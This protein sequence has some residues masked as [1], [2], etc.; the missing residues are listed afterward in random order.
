M[1]PGRLGLNELPT[2]SIRPC[3]AEAR[4]G[5]PGAERSTGRGGVDVEDSEDVARRRAGGPGRSHL[6]GLGAGCSLSGGWRSYCAVLR[7]YHHLCRADISVGCV[8]HSVA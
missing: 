1:D 3:G 5:G 4:A 7:A 2:K 8:D 6:S